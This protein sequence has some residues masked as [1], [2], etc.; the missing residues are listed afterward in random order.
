MSLNKECLTTMLALAVGLASLLVARADNLNPGILIK[1]GQ[2]V[3]FL[4]ASISQYGWQHPTGYIRL[5][6]ANLAANGVPIVPIP[7][8]VSGN[9]SK[10]MLARLDKDVI[11]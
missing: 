7:A 6:V 9:T 3:A 4:G 1:P 8:G 5:V 10:Q 2:K 11:D